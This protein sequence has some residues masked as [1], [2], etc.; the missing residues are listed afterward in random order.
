M[1]SKINFTLKPYYL[2]FENNILQI[3]HNLNE[4]RISLCTFLILYVR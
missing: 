3:R 1:R 4:G 2:S